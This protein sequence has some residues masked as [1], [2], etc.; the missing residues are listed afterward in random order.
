MFQDAA[1]LRLRLL[2]GAQSF[3][4]L[5]GARGRAHSAPNALKRFCNLIDSLADY[6]RGNAL[7]VAVAT[8]VKLYGFDDI[9]VQFHI[10]L[11]GTS[12]WVL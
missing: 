1:P 3:D 8:A 11:L 7:Q 5:V 9:A 6:N 4:K 12:P 2:C 10:N